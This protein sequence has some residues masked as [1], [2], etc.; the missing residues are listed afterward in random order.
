MNE[1][2]AHRP[3]RFFGIVRIDLR[4]DFEATA[5]PGNHT[6][7]VPRGEMAMMVRENGR[8]LIPP[9]G[10]TARGL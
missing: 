9:A 4:Q 2:P 6:D 3:D 5:T 8:S 10:M 1:T 7:Y